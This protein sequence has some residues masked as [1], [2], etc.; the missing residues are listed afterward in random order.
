MT[1]DEHVDTITDFKSDG[2]P[3]IWTLDEDHDEQDKKSDDKE[4]S[5]NK[6][7]DDSKESELEKPSF[8]RR[9]AKRYKNPGTE[10]DKDDK[11]EDKKS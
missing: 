6:D 2:A 9:L 11:D 10:H 7:A 8:L 4:D 1:L 5:D 3:N